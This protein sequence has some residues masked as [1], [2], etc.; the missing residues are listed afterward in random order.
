M[1]WC[2]AFIGA[3]RT[4]PFKGFCRTTIGPRSTHLDLG[5]LELLGLLASSHAEPSGDNVANGD[6]ETF[7]KA[8]EAGDT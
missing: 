4:G 8:M 5:R 6:L 7:I 3:L 2:G 1:K